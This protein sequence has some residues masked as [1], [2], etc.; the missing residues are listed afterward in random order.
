MVAVVEMV[1]QVVFHVIIIHVGIGVVLAR[2][3]PL[4]PARWQRVV[5]LVI[6]FWNRAATPGCGAGVGGIIVVMPG[7]RCVHI[8]RE[9][10]AGCSGADAR[11]EMPL[12]AAQP[13]KL[14]VFA[15]IC[16]FQEAEQ[17]L[18]CFNYTP[19]TD[20]LWI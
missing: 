19:R 3:E 10:W 15:F 17:C 7:S 13:N 6:R 11:Q 16:L 9:S 12:I 2:L 1:V 18:D 4:R 5:G 20:F 14:N 8:M